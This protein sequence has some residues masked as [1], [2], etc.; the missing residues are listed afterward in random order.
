MSKILNGL[1]PVYSRDQFV[2]RSDD[3][4]T[5]ISA[6]TIKNWVLKKQSAVQ[7]GKIYME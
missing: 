7:W 5:K 4:Q 3:T 1:Q 2:Y 6:A